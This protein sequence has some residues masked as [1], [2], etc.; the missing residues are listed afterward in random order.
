MNF[1]S[2]TMYNKP[3]EEK[4]SELAQNEYLKMIQ[5]TLSQF[6]NDIVS[7]EMQDNWNH[8]LDIKYQFGTMND[9]IAENFGITFNYTITVSRLGAAFRGAGERYLQ[10]SCSIR[11]SMRSKNNQSDMVNNWLSSN[12]DIS[13]LE[14]LKGIENKPEVTQIEQMLDDSYKFLD[15]YI[16]ELE[17]SMSTILIDCPELLEGFPDAQEM[18]IF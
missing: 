1:N 5:N 10:G 9:K 4:Y 8:D 7:I 18:F 16:K 15:R 17:N 12:K 11:T 2:S 6:S 14:M 3:I 13:S